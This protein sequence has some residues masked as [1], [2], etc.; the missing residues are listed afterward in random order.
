MTDYHVKVSGDDGTGDG[1]EGNPFRQIGAAMSVCS[2]GGSAAFQSSPDRVLVHYDATGTYDAVPVEV[3]RGIPVVGVDSTG[4]EWDTTDL[5]TLI[6]L[7]VRDE[8][9]VIT[10]SSGTL[11]TFYEWQSWHGLILDGQG[12]ATAGMAAASGRYETWCSNV[13]IR[14]VDGHAF[15]GADTGSIYTRIG[16][17][18]CDGDG[19]AVNG[20]AG[21]I[22]VN[23]FFALR[24]T[25]HGIASAKGQ[26]QHGVVVG[27][28][29]G[30]GRAVN[31]ADASTELRNWIAYDND[32]PYGFGSGPTLTNCNAY[33]SDAG[34][35]HTTANYEGG[36][37]P[38]TCLSV[39][40][41][42]ADVGADDLTLAS[43]SPMIGAGAVQFAVSA[44]VFGA[45]FLGTEWLSP[46]AIGAYEVEAVSLESATAVDLQNINALFSGAV[47]AATVNGASKW[48]V[49][50]MGLA[51]TVTV[52]AAVLQPDGVTVRL[53]VHPG[54]TPGGS[55]TVEAL[56]AEY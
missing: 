44:G 46:P 12:T 20:F 35:Y 7:L 15:T 11:V 10:A 39:D 22:E 25:G 27:C 48:A 2:A 50:P 26:L 52:T 49:T 3:D 32:T 9:P 42:F 8:R 37:V 51:N 36:G 28:G 21:A 5:P 31:I 4:A 14:N 19:L 6:G 53:V 16:A 38:A 43:G 29:S 41:L 18:D 1:S 40:P 55:Y 56:E 34:S 24:C 45:D 23:G 17:M 47:I 13:L 33:T 54:V 30:S